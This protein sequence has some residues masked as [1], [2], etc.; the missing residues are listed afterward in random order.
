MT[1]DENLSLQVCLCSS[2]TKLKFA[3]EDFI[4]ASKKNG[5]PLPDV[6]YYVELIDEF[7]C[8][9]D[10]RTRDCLKEDCDNC[11]IKALDTSLF[12]PFLHGINDDAMLTYR[13]LEK[14]ESGRLGIQDKSGTPQQLV[15]HLRS[16]LRGFPLHRFVAKNQPKELD[17]LLKNLNPDVLVLMSDYAEKYQRKEFEEVQSLHWSGTS[18]TIFTTVAFF[19]IPDPDNPHAFK[20]IKT[21]FFITTERPE[22]DNYFAAFCFRLIIKWIRDTFRTTFKSCILGSDKCGQQFCSRK[23]FGSIAESRRNLC[24]SHST[25]APLCPNCPQ[26]VI[27]FSAAGHGKGE[28]DHAGAYGKTK[29]R[30]EELHQRPLRS[31]HDVSNFLQSL[32]FVDVHRTKP[33]KEDTKGFFYS[34]FHAEVVQPAAVQ[35][36]SADWDALERTR[37][38]HQLITTEVSGELLVRE[39]SCFSC[40][41]CEFGNYAACK[42]TEELGPIS[43]VMM[44]RA[45]SSNAAARKASRTRAGQEQH[46]HECAELAMSGSV[47]A[48]A[49]GR[50]QQINLVLVTKSMGQLTDPNMLKGRIL[51]KT[52]TAN[53]YTSLGSKLFSFNAELVRSPPLDIQ[54]LPS[55]VNGE[56]A[57][58]YRIDEQEFNS[59]VA[60]YLF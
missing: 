2:H 34:A 58:R 50:Q 21:Y 35:T 16:H 57:T 19:L 17:Y 42:R 46:R 24:L 9:E 55:A 6:E 13:S 44:T 22:Q 7:L 23:V 18:L 8:S 12:E 49:Q 53:E 33:G 28:H 3:F 20:K 10:D 32:N 1:K 30:L 11:G 37:T 54:T 38:F 14:D 27:H 59:L 39:S 31:I 4:K 25:S 40:S 45:S 36:S 26:A 43:R 29:L 41:E 51:V 52:N 5:I 60:E 56:S 15:D 48:V 47:I